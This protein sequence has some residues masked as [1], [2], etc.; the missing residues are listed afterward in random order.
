MFYWIYDLP[1][2]TMV[3]MVCALFVGVTWLGT[4][5]VRP[6][7]RAFLRRQP[8][9]NDIVGYLLGAHGVYFGLLLGLLALASYQNF[10]DVEKLV[11]DE[12]TKLAALYRDTSAWS[13]AKRAQLA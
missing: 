4:S 8:G 7:L 5:F 11:V 1:T 3:F 13:F 6:F 10:S 2:W 12:A 9:L